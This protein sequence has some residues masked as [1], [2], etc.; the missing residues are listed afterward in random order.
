MRWSGDSDAGMV[1]VA[2]PDFAA[3]THPRRVW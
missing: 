2:D 3:T 1:E